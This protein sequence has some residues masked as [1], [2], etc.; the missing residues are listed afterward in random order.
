MKDR[1]LRTSFPTI[2]Q[3]LAKKPTYSE[4][5]EVMNMQRVATVLENRLRCVAE[6]YKNSPEELL[7]PNVARRKTCYRRISQLMR[8]DA[9]V[10]GEYL[11]NLMNQAVRPLAR[12]PVAENRFRY[13]AGS[14]NFRVDGERQGVFQQFLVLL[15]SC[16]LEEDMEITIPENLIFGPYGE[17][18]WP[19]QQRNASNSLQKLTVI[20]AH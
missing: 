11:E 9:V 7:V 16:V 4:I 6:W 19:K 17:Q 15:A 3:S 13:N 18:Y 2:A 12:D 1:Y 20:Y 14:G 5:V 8:A 10:A